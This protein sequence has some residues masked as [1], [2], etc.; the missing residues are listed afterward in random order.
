MF[1]GGLIIVLEMKISSS[2][3]CKDNSEKHVELMERGREHR[4]AKVTKLFIYLLFRN[5]F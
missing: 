2:I 5:A 3:L 1:R 4:S